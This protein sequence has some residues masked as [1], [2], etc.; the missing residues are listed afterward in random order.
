MEIFLNT[1]SFLLG[2][3]IVIIVIP[4]I[5]KVSFA[6]E[7]FD[8]INSR[9]VH[10]R[11]IPPMGGVAILI[12]FILS[13]I[14][15]TGGYLFFELKYIIA[16]VLILF[17]I[18]LKDDLMD[19]SA[20]KR[21]MVQIFAA[22]LLITFGDIQI[23]NLHGLLGIYQLHH[24]TGFLLT[25]FIMLSI[26]N[27]FNLIDGID[28]LASGLGIMASVIFGTW[29][30][31]SGHVEY[32]ILAFALLGSLMAFF[33][34]NV[35]GTKHKLFMGDSGSLVVGMLVAILSIKFNQFN[36]DMTMPF[37]IGASPTVSFAVVVVPLID[38]LRV[39]TIRILQ[40]RSPFV[41]DN[42]HIHHRILT[43]VPNHFKVSLIMI[44]A[45]AFFVGIAL[46]E[47]H[48]SFNRTFQFL[49]LFLVAL[50]ASFI[51]SVLN[52]IKH[53]V[54]KKSSSFAQQFD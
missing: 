25:L 19:I 42:N 23:T 29:F 6:K 51:P 47:N 26:I 46:F 53:S 49:V 52:R 36:I 50:I 20:R 11:V 27:A 37:A 22:V 13:T 38:M 31:I 5:L 34:Y 39:M 28:G 45:N 43:L 10:T 30:Y 21:F 2:F 48:F 3:V 33:I 24:Y 17:F 14:I 1:L 15:S 9:K 41:A 12:G 40:G 7:L 8:H 54:T 32:A 4:S 44:T 16:A 18:G 35:F